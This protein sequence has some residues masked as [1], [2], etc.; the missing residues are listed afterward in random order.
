MRDLIATITGP[1]GTP[2]EGGR[3]QLSLNIPLLYP[4]QPPRVRFITKV[5]HP[6]VSSISGDLCLDV[7]SHRWSSAM[8]INSTLLSIQTLLQNPVPRSPHDYDVATI[9]RQNTMRHIQIAKYWT[10]Y[11]A[12]KDRKI[13]PDLQ[14]IEDRVQQEAN[15][16]RRSRE[17]V[18]IDLS[19]RGFQGTKGLVPV[20]QR[21]P[22]LRQRI[23]RHRQVRRR[24]VGPQNRGRQRRPIP[25]RRV[26]RQRQVRRTPVG[27]R[28]QVQRRKPVQQRKGIQRG[29]QARPRRQV[30]QQR[31]NRK[32]AGPSTSR[33]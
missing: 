28:R 5:W 12:T 1:P 10:Q 20:G 33:S 32:R 29:R 8:T 23:V 31:P 16:G 17:V 30:R 27:Q 6:N 2:Y 25:R 19:L 7:L 24:P 15:R 11:F 21:T 4:L 3:F 26:V 18:I 13:T 14:H 9:M 22:V